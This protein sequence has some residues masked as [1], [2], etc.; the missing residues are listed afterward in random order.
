MSSVHRARRIHV[1]KRNSREA[2]HRRSG[3]FMSTDIDSLVQRLDRHNAEYR[4]GCPTIADSEYDALVEELRSAAPDHPLLHQVEV[5]SFD[6]KTR[7][8]HPTPMLSTNKAYTPQELQNFVDRVHKAAADLGADVPAFRV[9]PKLDGLAGRDDG[10]VLATRG[11]GQSGFDVTEA[12]ARG[13]VPVGGRAP[14][15]GEIVMA[16]SYFTKVLSKRFDHPRNLVVGII[17]SDT[18]SKDAAAALESGSVHFVR[19]DTLPRWTGT[20][21]ELIARASE[22]TEELRVAVDYPLDG[23]VAEVMDPAIQTH[24]G[25]T[26]HHNRWQIALKERGET[27]ETIVQE[28]LWQTGRT[29]KITPVLQ[30]DPTRLSGATISRITA[31]H[32]GAVRDQAIGPGAR[33]EII[34][35]GEVIPKLEKVLIA[36]QQVSLPE[37]C[38]SCAAALRWDNDFLRCPNAETCPAQ[39]VHGIRHWFHIL[40]NADWFGI[41]TV[42][43]LVAGGFTSLEKVYAMTGLDLYRMGFGPGQTD[44]LLGALEISRRASIPDARF[45]AAFGLADLGIGESRNLLKRFPLA[46]LATLR[47]E[48]LKAIK[49]F[50]DVTSERI[51]EGLKAR[52]STIQHMLNLGFTLEPTPLVSEKEAFEGPIAGKNIVFTGAMELGTRSAMKAQAQELGANVQSAVSKNTDLL[53]HG[54]KPGG[55]KFNK[56]THLGIETLDE[57]A[58]LTRIGVTL[59]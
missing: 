43:R 55:S 49:G 33:I 13:V 34:R 11:D 50:G 40:G 21:A 7:V 2:R 45:L 32:A 42:E 8:R 58:Y 27:A 52:W 59:S 39:V 51:T 6:N 22:I 24:M 16:Q 28:V 57:R 17:S 23:M 10:E 1:Y 9:T 38:P 12:F 25:S 3:A 35:S 14:G 44:N 48:E 29:G 53:V 54:S 26:H 19:Y 41:K 56:A 5:E 37:T 4:A 15:V 46:S 47:A 36:S 18:L 31:H 20:G 30:V